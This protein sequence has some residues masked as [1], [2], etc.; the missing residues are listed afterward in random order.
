MCHYSVPIVAQHVLYSLH[1]LALWVPVTTGHWQCQWPRCGTATGERLCSGGLKIAI[2]IHKYA[3]YKNQMYSHKCSLVG[4]TN[5]NWGEMAYF[6]GIIMP[7]AQLKLCVQK[8]EFV[9]LTW[10]SESM[11][12]GTGDVRREFMCSERLKDEVE[13]LLK[14][15]FSMFNQLLN[16]L[17]THMRV[18]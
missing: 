9:I 18:R 14:L 13:Q 15:S 2:E 12:S 6:H 4:N 3:T 8:Y 10:N 11:L 1:Y 16:S 7:N 5:I 17:S